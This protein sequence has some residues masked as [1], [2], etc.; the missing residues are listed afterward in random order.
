MTNVN[1]DET[2][3]TDYKDEA[4][5]SITSIKFKTTDKRIRFWVAAHEEVFSDSN[6]YQFGQNLI[7]LKH[8]D[9]S[10]RNLIVK[11]HLTTG[12]NTRVQA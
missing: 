7:T 4:R 8:K 9:S 6:N 11:F 10:N 3:Y 5:T 1:P 2:L 12:A